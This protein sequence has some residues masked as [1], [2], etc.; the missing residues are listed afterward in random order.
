MT[1]RIHPR[2]TIVEW[3][4]ANPDT[5][6][7]EATAFRQG[8]PAFLKRVHDAPTGTPLYRM[9]P[10]GHHFIGRAHEGTTL[11]SVSRGDLKTG[12]FYRTANSCLI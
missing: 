2:I 12:S 1:L 6:R 10:R 4:P 5:V 7:A 9:R 3:F 11:S 8:V